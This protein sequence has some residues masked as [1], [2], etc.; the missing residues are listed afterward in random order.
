MLAKEKPVRVGVIVD[1]CLRRGMSGIDVARI[2]RLIIDDE[3][4]VEALYDC[5]QWKEAIEIAHS[6]HTKEAR[7]NLLLLIKARH[8]VKAGENEGGV[9]A[10]IEQALGIA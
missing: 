5:G 2:A 9:S 7:E 6:A 10:A 4:R 3:E 1:A 8:L